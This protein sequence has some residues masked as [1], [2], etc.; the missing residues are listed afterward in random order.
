VSCINDR[1]RMPVPLVCVCAWLAGVSAAHVASG[2]EIT[3]AGKPAQLD[4]R[5]VGTGGLRVTLRPLDYTRE[6]PDSP[7]LV[8]RVAAEPEISLQE[9][10]GI[11]NRRV[12][13]MFVTVSDNP[14]TVDVSTADGT[15]VQNV[16]FTD[17][18]NVSFRLD[19]RPVLGLG[20]GGPEMGDDWRDEPLEYDRRGR[21]HE[22]APRWQQKAYGSRNPVAMVIGTSGWAVYMNSPW[23]EVDLRDERRGLFIPWQPPQG[24]SVD[25]AALQ[26]RPVPGSMVAGL[27]DFFIF[28]ASDPPTFMKD[29]SRIAGQAVMP[30]KWTL[31]YMQ[32]HRLLEDDEQMIEIVDTFR[33][34]RIPVDA[35]IY[36]GTGFTP[37]GWNTE[38]PS[39]TFNPEVFKR[40]PADVVD[41]LHDRNVKVVV[42]IVP[43]ADAVRL[44]GN[45][46]ARDGETVDANHVQAHWQ[47]HVPL[48]ETGVDAFWPDEGDHFDLRSRMNRHRMYYQGPLSA[49]PNRRPWSLHRNGHL[50]IAR[51]GGW[52]WSGDTDSSWRT[53]EAQVR[54]G[55]NHSLS[56][57]PYWGSDIGGFYPNEELTGELYIRWFQFAAFTPSFRAHGK[58]W[59]TRLPWGFGLDDMGPREHSSNPLE[60]ELGNP[61][62]EGIARKYAELRYRLLPYNYTLAWQARDSGLPL[63]RALWLHYPEDGTAAAIGS[64]YLWGRDL[65][66]APVMT[67]GTMARDVYLPTGLWYDWWTGEKVVGGTTTT[68]IVDLE[69]MPIYARAG[70][71]I[72]L[73]PVRQYVA[74]RVTDPTVLRIFRGSD[75]EFTLYDDD[76]TTLNY[77]EGNAT[78]TRI[79]W[80]DDAATLTIG[81]APTAKANARPDSRQFRVELVPDGAERLV[82]Y[83][84]RRVTVDF[85][86]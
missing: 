10:D 34:K 39:F 13:R 72:P 65:L 36:L 1:G 47:G 20:E 60:S 29:V 7:S 27:F 69:T 86:D 43:P 83:I 8:R 77:L 59:W 41:D 84:G 9:I 49:R 21:L 67:K 80:D 63:M 16:V 71:I 52:M 46:P 5:A 54:V 15:S 25:P 61:A 33:A 70:A 32:S 23:A 17:D 78:L 79:A 24:D 31:G 82:T 6:F 4:V 76:G 28:D 38:Q 2:A 66:I 14:L 3:S 64:E 11:L 22:M 50:G 57:S 53:L 51:F 74:Q 45:V 44:S 68:K 26:G 56:L 75:G 40:E 73:D 55:L 37:R 19:G 58:T 81:P 42:H 12:G 48:L 18:G 85:S 62:I 30:P 35:V